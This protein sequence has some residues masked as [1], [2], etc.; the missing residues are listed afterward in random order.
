ML[1]PFVLENAARFSVLLLPWAGL[2]WLIGLTQRALRS[3]SWRHPALFAIVVTIVGGVNA[4]ALLL[5]G[6]A[7]LLW[8][9][10]AVWV[11]RE[12]SLRRALATVARIG[13]LT[14][15][16]SLWWMAGLSIQGGYGLDVLKY[17]ETVQA[18]ARTSM[19][20]EVLRGLG[21][22]FFYGGDKV[23]PWIEPSHGYISHV[24]LLAVGFAVPVLAIIA[25]VSTRWRYRAFF[26]AITF[27]GTAVAVGAYP[28]G[29]PS[30]LGALFKS[31]ATSSTA[32]L[33]MRSTAR[34]VPLVVLGLAILVA[35]GLA[36]LARRLPRPAATAST[37]VIILAVVG[38]PVLWTGD[39]FGKN[40]QRAEDVPSYWHQAASY[41]DSRGKATRVLEVPGK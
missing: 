10:F 3:G 36:A 7:P 27:V 34:A 40:L 6:I 30:P 26:V 29:S 20:S 25:A 32:G 16:C 38:L 11:H 24:W 23:G 41:L 4:T 22:W 17:S 21:Y 13:V 8:V 37:V 14:L 35:S 18:V 31:L 28:Y 19:S 15:G 1:T 9:P 33:A 39:F 2:P 12:V 5:A